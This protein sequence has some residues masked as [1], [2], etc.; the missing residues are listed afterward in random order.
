MVS[1]YWSTTFNVLEFFSSPN[2]YD[3]VKMSFFVDN[4][5]SMLLLYK[6]TIGGKIS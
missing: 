2:R 6:I 1:D 3:F 5:G 4:Y